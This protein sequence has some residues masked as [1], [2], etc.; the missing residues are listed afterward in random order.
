M[1]P[2]TLEPLI[3]TLVNHFVSDKSRPE[4]VTLGINTVRELCV[5]VPLAMDAALLA[6]LIEYRKDKVPPARP[7]HL[8]LSPLLHHRTSRVRRARAPRPPT[9]CRRRQTRRAGARPFFL[10]PVGRQ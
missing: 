10:S 4:V 6:D 5:R 7:L 8:S 1:P 2:E 3:K 9:Y